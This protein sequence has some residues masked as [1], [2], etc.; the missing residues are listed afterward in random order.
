[1]EISFSE[2]EQS[3]IEQANDLP[4]ALCLVHYARAFNTVDI[5]PMA[6]VLAASAT[7]ESQ[8]VFETMIGSRTILDY[9]LRKLKTIGSGSRPVAAE[10]ARFPSGQPC[11]A[12][13]QAAS[14]R[15]TNWLDKPLA[16]MTIKTNAVGQASTLLMIT[17]VPSPATAKGSGIFP[18][19]K[20]PPKEEP[21]RFI[22]NSPAFDEIRLYAFYLDGL[23]SLDVAMRETV[24][25]A[26][27][28]LP[29]MRIIE[30]TNDKMSE[31]VYAVFQSFC[32]N[33]FPSV[34]ATFNNLPIFRQQGLLDGAT[35]VKKLREATPLYVAVN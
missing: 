32:F 35:L 4:A 24:N 23:I 28:E 1:M 20:H 27:R 22:R 26:R 21:R 10:L 34:G 7:Y 14:D 13:Y 19:R 6:K 16:A 30:T 25:Q 18:G 5:G 31:D 11:V 2:S 3:W 29:G 12:L 8:S 17:C 33:G 9:F 15:D